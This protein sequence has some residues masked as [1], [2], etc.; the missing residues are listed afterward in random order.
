MPPTKQVCSRL[1][2]SL[3]LFV[4]GVLF[5]SCTTCVQ[6]SVP[7]PRAASDATAL[8]H[9]FIP[10][11]ALASYIAGE[12]SVTIADIAEKSVPSVVNIS[13]TRTIKQRPMELSPLF[14]N[15]FFRDFFGERPFESIP[16]ERK[17]NALGSGVIASTEGIILTNNHV[18]ENAE[19]LKITLWD[20]REFEAIIVG[21]DPKS[22]VAV[23]RL[24]T[25]PEGLVALPFGDSASLRLGEVVIAIGN[26]FG[27]GQTVTMG[28][29]SA[30]D[31]GNVGIV[32][33]GDF[34]QTDAAINPG[35]SGG[36]LVNMRGELVGINTA[37]L[38]RSGGY[39]GVGFAIPAHLAE[40]TMHSLLK[41]GKVVRGWLGVGIQD[42]NQT[43]AD[44]MGLKVKK[45]VLVSDVTDSSP[46]AKAGFKRRDV[47]VA[48]DGKAIT[49]TSRLRNQIA[50]AGPKT[51]LILDIWRDGKKRILK[52]TLGELSGD[53]ATASPAAPVDSDVLGITVTAIDSSARQKF[54][55][56]ETL[57]EGVVVTKV[58][59]TSRAAMAGVRP[60][61][62]VV[63]VNRQ[64][65][66]DTK[67][68]RS[69][70]AK[71]KKHTLFLINRGGMTLFVAIG[72]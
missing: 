5:I 31:R 50:I 20:G 35:N 13:A 61:D 54:A 64:P 3:S 52:V 30:L 39:Q 2:L 14:R 33:Y 60:G 71:D 68:F 23:L 17:Q 55:I 37:I 42:L 21:T 6:S 59:P 10:T 9:V 48:I 44:A 7:A 27:V 11:P 51:K 15:P 38:S 25:K 4:L 12:Q 28:I 67:G 32:D 72:R 26:P 34:I 43:L 65:V 49:S 66:K 45:G 22:D 47:I 8:E 70:L 58:D 16:K 53:S 63:E 36:A 40:P 24:K 57:R 19:E 62:V 56:S 1:R 41:D 69:L 46:A 29:V 18:V